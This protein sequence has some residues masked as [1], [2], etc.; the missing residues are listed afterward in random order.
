MHDD[1]LD[2]RADPV[3]AEAEALL[4]KVRSCLHYAEDVCKLEEDLR[5]VEERRVDAYLK[6]EAALRTQRIIQNRIGL[7]IILATGLVSMLIACLFM[8]ARALL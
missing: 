7:A 5:D 3:Q 8:V 1:P 2:P 6:R 4:V